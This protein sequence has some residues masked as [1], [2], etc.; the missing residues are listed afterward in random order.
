M[1]TNYANP[2]FAGLFLF[3]AFNRYLDLAVAHSLAVNLEA[4]DFATKFARGEC[5]K[6]GWEAEVR[7]IAATRG[8]QA[9]EALW[10]SLAITALFIGLGVAAAAVAGRVHPSLAWDVAK[11]L[12]AVGAGLAGWATLF[13]L[14]GFIRT[15]SGRGLHEVVRPILFQAIFLPGLALATVGQLLPQ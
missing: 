7:T 9:R 10:K 8:R 11:V 6:P 14:G 5:P 3:T 15:W 12:S 1:P 2:W 4:N 13:Q